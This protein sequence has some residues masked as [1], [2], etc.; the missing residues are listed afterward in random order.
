M[1][2]LTREEERRVLSVCGTRERALV[3]TPPS[4]GFV[5]FG[6][7]ERTLHERR[8]FVMNGGFLTISGGFSS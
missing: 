1:E 2:G 8:V 4:M 5:V 7:T 3:L 6:L